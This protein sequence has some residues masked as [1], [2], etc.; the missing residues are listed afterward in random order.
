MRRLIWGFDGRTY[1]IVG[2]PM[3]RLICNKVRMIHCI[4]WGVT[5]YNFQKY[6]SYFSEDWFCLSKQCRPW[7]NV[8][9]HLVLHR[10]QSI[11]LCVSNPQKGYLF[12]LFPGKTYVEGTCK[13]TCPKYI[14]QA[15]NILCGYLVCSLFR[16]K[17]NVHFLVEYC[18][19]YSLTRSESF[20]PWSS[21][22]TYLE[23]LD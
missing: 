18:I 5:C 19:I 1:H 3:P 8:A 11:R 7:W 23:N 20:G 22:C 12:S 17:E 16:N 21:I 2:N 10:L 14:K 9:F 15:S 4:H 13:R 6:C